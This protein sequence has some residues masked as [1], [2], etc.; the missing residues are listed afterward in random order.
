MEAAAEKY[1]VTWLTTRRPD[2][3][4]IDSYW[5]TNLSTMDLDFIV[6]K[7]SGFWGWLQLHIPGR[8]MRLSLLARIVQRLHRRNPFDAYA[9]V[10]DEVVLPKRGLQYVHY[11]RLERYQEAMTRPSWLKR[12]GVLQAYRWVCKQIGSESIEFFARNRTLANS[13]FTA[14]A[15]RRIMDTDLHVVHPPVFTRPITIPWSE[16]EE[17]FLCV[18]R[19]AGEKRISM[20]VQILERVRRRG[21]PVRMTIAGTWDYQELE[22]GPFEESLH[23]RSEW[24]N[25]VLDST[26]DELAALMQSCRYGIHGMEDEH[27]GMAPAEMQNAGCIVFAHNSGG[28]REIMGHDNRLL[29]DDVED[30]VEKICRVLSDSEVQEDLL[31]GVADRSKLFSS[32]RF[33]ST[34]VGHIEALLLEEES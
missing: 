24:I 29:Y 2:L 12:L 8:W 6:M 31:K 21:Y 16:R 33:K 10:L 14:S 4:R 15:I 9:S 13:E 30:A 7:E 25:L 5:G 23:A 11:P 20:M 34:F 1:D 32:E 27:F 28:P 26:Q 3:K 19:L 22:R 17:V 18:G